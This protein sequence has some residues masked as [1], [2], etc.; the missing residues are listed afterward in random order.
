MSKISRNASGLIKNKYQGTTRKV[1]CVCSGDCLRS[2]TA[3][4][5]LASPPWNY[6]TRSCGSATDFALVELNNKLVLWADVIVCMD[7]RHLSQVNNI[8]QELAQEYVDYQFK[9]VY[10]LLIEDDFDYRDPT[11]VS[12]LTTKFT[13]IFT[14]SDD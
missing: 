12:L 13:G 5:I 9:P 7:D 1:L 4:H 11:L 6:N 3:A 14:F 8:Q 10:N 2:P